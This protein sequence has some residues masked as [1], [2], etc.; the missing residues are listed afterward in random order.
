MDERAKKKLYN[1]AAWK[2]ARRAVLSRDNGECQIKLACCRG[3]A[4]SVDHI[5]P[6]EKGGALLDLGNLRAACR[7]CNSAKAARGDAPP[8]SV[9][10]VPS[11]D[12]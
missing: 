9:N 12:W 11:R 7:P 5:V 2:Q 10:Y 1:S 6:I 3:A 8:P 4:D